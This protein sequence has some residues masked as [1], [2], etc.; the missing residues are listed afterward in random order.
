MTAAKITAETFEENIRPEGKAALIEFW[1]PWCP[2]CRRIGPAMDKV[3]EQY[4]NEL[5]VGQVNIDDEPALADR[6]QADTIPTLLYFQDGQPRGRV[7]APE[8]KAAI[9]RFIRQQ[10]GGEA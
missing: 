8:S 6:F 10:Q 3:A 7:V 1:A 4:R 9:D 2:Y 5:L